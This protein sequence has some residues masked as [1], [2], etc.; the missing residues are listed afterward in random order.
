MNQLGRFDMAKSQWCWIPQTRL[1]STILFKKSGAT[2]TG[3]SPSQA[4]L[5]AL[6]LSSFLHGMFFVMMGTKGGFWVLFWAYALAAFA[7]AILSGEISTTAN[8]LPVLMSYSIS[9]TVS[10]SCASLRAKE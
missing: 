1:G 8:I 10:T 6:L 5:Q 3:F 4:R 2:N 9:V 7:R